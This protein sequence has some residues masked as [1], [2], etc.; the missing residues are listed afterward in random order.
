MS[1]IRAF[2]PALLLLAAAALGGCG[3]SAQEEP[4]YDKDLLAPEQANYE[5]VQAGNGEYIR[6]AGGSMRLYYPVTA[7]LRWEEGSARFREILVRKGQEVKAG[8]SLAVFDID[9][10]RADREALALSLA[11]AIEDAELGKQERLTA[12]EEAGEKLQELAG[13]ELNIAR[14]RMEKA[15]AEYEQFVY[16]SEREIAR[17]RESLE[18]IDQEIADDTLFA[19]FDGVID[20]VASYNPGDPATKDIVV[21]SMHS[22]DRF[23]LV[24]EDASGRLRYNAEVTVEAGRRNDRKTYEG[25]VVAAPSILPSSVPRGMALVELYGDVPVEKLEGNLQYQFNVEELQDVLLVDWGALDSEKGK[26]FVYVLEDDMVQKRYVVPGMNN[27][28]KVWIL[29]GLHEGQTV[30]AD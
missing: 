8:D 9:V 25:R 26:N 16:Q 11:R 13:H 7:E 4:A 27:R 14:L 15:Q 10:S 28:E 23:Y 3:D 18:E 29:D 5:T 17:L 1:R 19:P 30:I 20:T 24:A 21:V 2:G 12:M 6:T 22:T